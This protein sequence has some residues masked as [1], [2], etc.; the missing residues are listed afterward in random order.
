M[1]TEFC[2]HFISAMVWNAYHALQGYEM[3][4]S[5]NFEVKDTHFLKQIIFLKS[6]NSLFC[7]SARH[8]VMSAM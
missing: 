1:E 6:I 5:A 2:T 8:K 3:H 7:L 4:T